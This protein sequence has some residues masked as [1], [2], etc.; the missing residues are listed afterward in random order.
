MS[1]NDFIET[2]NSVAIQKLVE[3]MM[4][5]GRTCFREIIWEEISYHQHLY[6]ESYLM[7]HPCNKAVDM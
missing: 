5:K 4:T 7:Y 1:V 3:R 2:Q 6:L